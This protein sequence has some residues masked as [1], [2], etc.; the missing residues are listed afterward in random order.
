[1]I[2]RRRRLLS[3]S[4]S[5]VIGLNRRLPNE[6]ARLGGD[7]WEVTAVAPRAFHDQ[8]RTARYEPMPDELCRVRPIAV[9]LSSEPHVFFWGRGLRST[10]REPWDVVHIWEEPYSV[11]GIQPALVTPR[12]TPFVF[13]TFQNIPKR[14]PP[15]F[16]SL[17]RAVLRRSKGWIAYGETI[18]RAQAERYGY[19][20]RPMAM[21][22]PGVDVDLFRPDPARG[23]AVRSELGW[24]AEGAPVIG[25]LGR[26]VPEKGLGTMTQALE[27]LKVPW[28]ALLVGTGPMEKEL[29]LWAE[30]QGG[31]AVLATHVRH[32]QVPA[33]LN[34][35]DLL[36]VPSLTRKNWREQFGRM[37]T[38]AF[39]SG[40]PVVS[41]DSGEL[42][43]TVGDA[44]KVVREGDREGWV[45]AIEELVTS[46]ERRRELG[47]RGR[48]R[49]TEHFA[50][51]VVARK[52]LEFLERFAS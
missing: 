2:K 29:E 39:A 47:A 5:Y 44:G 31:R 32:H 48:R 36:V 51:P 22:P 33:Y 13:A 46:P 19:G 9:H 28:R 17:E 20:R 38:E 37:V 3:I 21:I 24:G 30:R 4:H 50:W 8:L 7:D 18:A 35:M 42:P 41:S 49:A 34:A 6:L 11:G 10:L 15:P 1:M 40:V 45:R 43:F 14:Y 16:G 26:F 23:M 25:Y 12:T 52:T 27:A